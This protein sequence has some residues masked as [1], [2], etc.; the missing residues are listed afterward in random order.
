M[1]RDLETI[2]LKCL[3]KEPAAALRVGAGAG[4]R[5]GALPGRGS[6]SR[7][8]RSGLLERAVRWCRRNPALAGLLGVIGG[9][10]VTLAVGGYIAAMRE[11]GLREQEKN[12]R[13]AAE[14]AT[15]LA[16]QETTR[17]EKEAREKAAA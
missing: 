5:P 10:L 15:A 8:G 2:C 11:S 14:A 13:L 3:E 16:K 17:A 6:R 4:R 12:Q 9:L 7:P 1:D